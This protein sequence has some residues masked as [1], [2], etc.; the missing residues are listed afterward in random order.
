[1]DAAEYKHIVLGL[2]CLRYISDAFDEHRA[3]LPAAF[4]DAASDLHLPDAGDHADALEERDD[5]NLA[6]VFWVPAAARWQRRCVHWP[7]RPPSACASTP[8]WRPPRPTP[9]G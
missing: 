1:M 2:L 8:R 4:A 5:C 3:Q 6:S 7:S 9:R